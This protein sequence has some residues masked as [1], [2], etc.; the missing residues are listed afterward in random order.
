MRF[1]FLALLFFPSLDSLRDFE[2]MHQG[3]K[4]LSSFS[5]ARG[6]VFRMSYQATLRMSSTIEP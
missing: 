3:R 1:V 2:F 5:S 4:V 6:E